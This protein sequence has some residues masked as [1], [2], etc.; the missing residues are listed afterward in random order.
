LPE[1]TAGAAPPRVFV[2]TSRARI[3][4]VAAMGTQPWGHRPP[5]FRFAL[6]VTVP[7]RRRGVGRAL[8][9]AAARE[10][11]GLGAR[12]LR[13]WRSVELEEEAAFLR[14]VGF[15][16]TRRALHFEADVLDFLR[17][18]QTVRER[19]IAHRRVPED[20]RVVPLREADRRAVIRLCRRHL[21]GLPAGLRHAL[22][23]RS[24]GAASLEHSVVLRV[25]ETMCG[26]LIYG[27]EG[28]TARIDVQLLDPAFRRTWAS[29]LLLAGAIERGRET[30]A[31]R[32]RFHC[33][34]DNRDTLKLAE[35]IRARLLKAEDFYALDLT[36]EG[37]R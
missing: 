35:R 3:L 6:R 11:R 10:A 4:G 24:Q 12:A 28:D 22:R 26:V 16:R 5:G 8:V 18:L 13:A 31:S 29:I 23:G 19:L 1:I 9:Q 27:W 36:G 2:A 33:Y 34:D 25:G 21:E 15:E 17:H 7:Y 32:I 14:S 30:G 37:F 20:A